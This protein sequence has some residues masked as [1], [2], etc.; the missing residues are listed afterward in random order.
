MDSS[1]V[2]TTDGTTSATPAGLSPD[3]STSSIGPH[4]SAEAL[5][6]A[7][8]CRLLQQREQ[9]A[10]QSSEFAAFD[11]NHQKRQEFRRLIEPGILRL[12]PKHIAMESL[13]V[14]NFLTESFVCP[15]TACMIIRSY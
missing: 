5:S 7:A 1:S 13:R 10:G 6:K 15:M 8:E 9:S 4:Y 2:G 11:C 3:G 12:N 14:H